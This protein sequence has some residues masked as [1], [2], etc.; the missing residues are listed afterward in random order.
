M[1]EP[2]ETP[3]PNPAA[4]PRKRTRLRKFLWGLLVLFV[5][6]AIFH[7]PLFHSGVRLL[8]IKVAARQNLDLDVNFSGTIWTNLTV[9]DVLAV[10]N[11][12]GETPVKRI[13][14]ER[15]RLDYSLWTLIRR[16]VGEFLESYEITNADLQFIARESKTE[17]EK[18]QKRTLAQDLNNILAQ[19]AAYADRVKIQNFNISVE[20]DEEPTRVQGIHIFL[21]PTEVGHLRIARLQAPGVP[22]WENLDAATTYRNRNLMITELELGPQVVFDVI[23]FDA[24]QRAQDKGS[25]AIKARLFGGTF[26]LSL[27][28]T[29]LKEKGENLERATT[30][31]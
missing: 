20:A 9:R 5:L 1:T 31:R 15:V 19:P 18:E 16:G 13:A 27:A 3:Q 4:K 11:G 2:A 30:R 6:L 8:L 17:D 29:K 25:M 23:N 12:T 21:H 22:V 24:S 7:R 26:E 14:I 28:G 10:P